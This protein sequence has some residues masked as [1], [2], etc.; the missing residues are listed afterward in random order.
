MAETGLQKKQ[1]TLYN[2]YIKK[3]D[4]YD[5]ELAKLQQEKKTIKAFKDKK[6]TCIQ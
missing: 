3:Q 5:K 4:V 1:K 6:E 2:A